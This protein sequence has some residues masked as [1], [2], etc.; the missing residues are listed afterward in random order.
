MLPSS[1]AALRTA[2]Y[3]RPLGVVTANPLAGPSNPPIGMPLVAQNQARTLLTRRGASFWAPSYPNNPG[4]TVPPAGEEL[5]PL[6][7]MS[8]V[9]EPPKAA[10]PRVLHRKE[11]YLDSL[12]DK[13]G[14]M[15]LQCRCSCEISDSRLDSRLSW[16]LDS[17]GGHVSQ[18]GPVPSS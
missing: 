9:T 6:P 11:R 14:E 5:P 12:M 17:R 4:N 1:R 10:T 2:L 3:L 18:N 16:E 7:T 13:A 8:P 15:G